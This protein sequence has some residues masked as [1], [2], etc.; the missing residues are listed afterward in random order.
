MLHITVLV[1]L[2]IQFLWAKVSM[3]LVIKLL[4]EEVLVHKLN[5]A[6]VSIVNQ[7]SN[8]N[9]QQV[10]MEQSIKKYRHFV[11]DFVKLVIIVLRVVSA[12]LKYLAATPLTTVQ[13]EVHYR[14]MFL[15]DIIQLKSINHH[16]LLV[17][18]SLVRKHYV[19]LDFIV[20]V[21]AGLD[22]VCRALMEQRKDLQAHHVLGYVRLD[23]TAQL[24][25]PVRDRYRV[26]GVM[27]F[28]PQAHHNQLP[29]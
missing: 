14:Y 25:H 3:L 27:C 18:K 13:L 4:K 20:M 6:L 11:L 26:A 9:V 15:P 28:A 29:S 1:I 7:V 2:L 8:I 24:V 21:T 12:P 16:H 17:N 23:I 22:P 10:D 5:V 19:A